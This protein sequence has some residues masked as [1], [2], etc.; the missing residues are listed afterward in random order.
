MKT[1]K[2]DIQNPVWK[3]VKVIK[4]YQQAKLST[5]DVEIIHGKMWKEIIDI[6][7]RHYSAVH[8]RGRRPLPPDKLI[9][10]IYIRVVATPDPRVTFGVK[11]HQKRRGPV[12]M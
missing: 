9:V 1:K 3:S 8:S 6:R 10:I 4:G 5:K 12:N 7:G 11:S 2:K